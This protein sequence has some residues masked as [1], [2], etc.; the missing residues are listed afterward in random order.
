MLV[1]R[2]KACSPA[3][4]VTLAK[5][6]FLSLYARRQGSVVVF[7][8]RLAAISWRGFYANQSSFSIQR[9]RER[10]IQF[11]LDLRKVFPITSFGKGRLNTCFFYLFVFFS[12]FHK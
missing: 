5:S 7:F 2:L 10:T 8:S 1:G 12:R 11:I 3:E 4:R 9:P 6:P